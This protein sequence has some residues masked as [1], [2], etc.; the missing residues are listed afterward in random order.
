MAIKTELKKQF[1]IILPGLLLFFN[2]LMYIFYTGEMYG[3]IKPMDSVFYL[4]IKHIC[5]SSFLTLIYITIKR[6]KSIFFNTDCIKL[7]WIYWV[8]NTPYII[9]GLKTDIYFIVCNLL[10]FSTFVWVTTKYIL[11]NTKINAKKANRL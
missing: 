6:Y 3:Y 4:F 2:M 1:G 10:I 9:L 7:L 8:I 11:A 5:E